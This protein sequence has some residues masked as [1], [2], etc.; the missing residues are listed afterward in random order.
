M[1]EL[2]RR[3]GHAS[4]TS[5]NRGAGCGADYGNRYEN[6]ETQRG[7]TW[8][9]NGATPIFFATGVS[10]V[11][12]ESWIDAFGIGRPSF[13]VGREPKLHSHPQSCPTKQ[14]TRRKARERQIIPVAVTRPTTPTPFVKTEEG[15]DG[16]E[17]DKN[18]DE[19]P[20][21]SKCEKKFV[22]A[23]CSTSRI[24][25]VSYTKVFDE[26]GALR[27]TG[28]SLASANSPGVSR[29]SNLGI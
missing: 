28:F 9:P 4:E 12:A 1:G 29:G 17:V 27:G 15:P 13:S 10:G 20:R 6:D 24:L 11:K 19:G 3:G 5:S 26:E 2:G 22:M 14:R 16:R 7:L 18:R 8:P 23:R 21:R 25:S